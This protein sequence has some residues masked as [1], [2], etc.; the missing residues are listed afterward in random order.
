M[1]CVRQCSQ[2]TG[3]APCVTARP[4][5]V[6]ELKDAVTRSLMHSK[7]GLCLMETKYVIRRSGFIYDGLG[8][9]FDIIAIAWEEHAPNLGAWNVIKQ[10][11]II[12]PTRHGT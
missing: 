11:C 1:S 8:D 6:A 2:Q 5:V 3:Y 12:A 4:E 10:E 9:Y 7:I